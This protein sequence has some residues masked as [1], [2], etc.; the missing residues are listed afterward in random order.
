MSLQYYQRETF[1]SLPSVMV[2][3]PALFFD[4]GVYD[5][6]YASQQRTVSGSLKQAFT[7]GDTVEGW[8]SWSRKD[9][10]ATPAYG[11]DGE[12]LPGEPLRGDTIWRA[13]IAWTHAF[14]PDRTGPVTVDLLV[15]YTCTRHE[16]NDL[17]YSYRSHI[18]GLGVTVGY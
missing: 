1:G 12:P 17:F 11:L 3:T 14:L 5:D 10:T 18:V 9:Y 7:R 16:S 6:P 2:V 15:N 4:D 13:G 8:G